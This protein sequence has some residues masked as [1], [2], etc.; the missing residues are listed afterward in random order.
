MNARQFMIVGLM[1]VLLT[2][3][4]IKTEVSTTH[5]DTLGWNITVVDCP[6][7]NLAIIHDTRVRKYN[8]R[9]IADKNIRGWYNDFDFDYK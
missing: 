6:G 8:F 3:F 2:V 5:D 9:W 4:L 1:L 7:F